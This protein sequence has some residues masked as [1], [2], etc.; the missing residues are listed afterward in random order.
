M[1]LNFAQK[2]Y[3]LYANKVILVG[4]QSHYRN[5]ELHL[6]N[7]THECIPKLQNRRNKL[8]NKWTNSKNLVPWCAKASSDLEWPGA[9]ELSGSGQLVAW[10]DWVVREMQLLRR[11]WE[12]RSPKS[13]QK[14]GVRREC[15]TVVVLLGAGGSAVRRH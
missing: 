7:S 2:S 9:S 8:Y 6:C 13:K 1:D 12:E 4:S 15:S 5:E 3:L 14:D 11:G 10:C